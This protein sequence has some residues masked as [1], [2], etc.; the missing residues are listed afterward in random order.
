MKFPLFFSL[1]LVI[2]NSLVNA[3]STINVG[4]NSATIE[5]INFDYS[6]GEMAVISSNRNSNIILTQGLLQCDYHPVSLPA[7]STMISNSINMKVYP[8]PVVNMLTIESN[9]LRSEKY[10]CLLKDMSGSIL[11]K[12]KFDTEKNNRKKIISM[13]P[14]SSGEYFLMIQ[15]ESSNN[16]MFCFKIQK[17]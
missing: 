10:I 5:G 1:F 11:L 2:A 14:F 7:I 17:K 3:Q 15:S 16:A 9:S 8:N 6:I 4:G 13:Q 12:E